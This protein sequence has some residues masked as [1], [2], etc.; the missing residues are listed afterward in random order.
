MK[1]RRGL[2]LALSVLWGLSG[3][4]SASERSGAPGSEIPVSAPR[5]GNCSGGGAEKNA[6]EQG[7]PGGGAEKNAGKKGQPGGGAEKN[8]GK[9]GQPGGGGAGNSGVFIP[10]EKPAAPADGRRRSS[11]GAKKGSGARRIRVTVP[12]SPAPVPAAG[13]KSKK[14]PAAGDKPV[15]RVAPKPAAPPP[16]GFGDPAVPTKRRSSRPA[17]QVVWETVTAAIRRTIDARNVTFAPLGAPNTS[18]TVL[19]DRD[20]WRLTGIVTV[21]TGNGTERYAF[22]CEAVVYAENYKCNVLKISFRPAGR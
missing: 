21:D 10:W 7:Q 1:N 13:G 15:K 3:C 6:G 9:K 18:L 8:A 12:S 2:M 17:E 5:A 22:D 14:A 19:G 20:R 11:G 4:K 16:G